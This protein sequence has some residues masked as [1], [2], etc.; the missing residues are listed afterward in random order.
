MKIDI[1]RKL[2]ETVEKSRNTLLSFTS[3]LDSL[4]SIFKKL[5]SF[6]EKEEFVEQIEDDFKLIESLTTICSRVAKKYEKEIIH[7]EIPKRTLDNFDLESFSLPKLGMNTNIKDKT[8]IHQKEDISGESQLYKCD[9]GCGRT[10]SLGALNIHRK[11]CKKIFGENKKISENKIQAKI[12][13]SQK[14]CIENK[15]K[16]KLGFEKEPSQTLR[17][18]EYCE[19]TFGRNYDTHVGVCKHVFKNKREPYD[20]KSHRI[21]QEMKECLDNGKVDLTENIKPSF[22]KEES[23]AFRTIVSALKKVSEK[24]KEQESEMIEEVVKRSKQNK[25]KQKKKKK[26]KKK[27]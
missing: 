6:E 25:K 10:F 26:N 15:E 2:K 4:E 19:R 27:N 23:E 16:I 14:T 1:N 21:I 8:I 11:I 17:K 7:F 9:Q 22:W 18:C 12:I 20:S 5:D 13:E 3:I 24:K